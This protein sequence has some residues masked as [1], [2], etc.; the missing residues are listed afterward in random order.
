LQAVIAVR[1]RLPLGISAYFSL[2]PFFGH[3]GLEAS[4]L[5]FVNY[6]LFL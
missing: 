3:T 5:R 1:S 4:E 6:L 2:D